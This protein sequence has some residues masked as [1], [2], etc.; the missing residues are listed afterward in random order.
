MGSLLARID[1]EV[2]AGRLWRAK[3]IVCGHISL[4]GFADSKVMS[5]ARRELTATEAFVLSEIQQYW[6]SQNSV[7]D[8]FFTERDEA[9]LFVR[10]RD[11]R[12]A[13][14]IALTNLGRWHED[15]TLS[16]ED[17]REQIKG[18]DARS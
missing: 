8:V 12:T 2:A 17:L 15:G 1:A 3:E 14:I 18:P 16:L 7:D 6:G 11:G 13:V 5:G 9:V 10:A 4:T